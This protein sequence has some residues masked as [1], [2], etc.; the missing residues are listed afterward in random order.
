M[1]EARATKAKKFDEN[2]FVTPKPVTSARKTTTTSTSRGYLQQKYTNISDEPKENSSSIMDEIIQ[3]LPSSSSDV[4]QIRSPSVSAAPSGTKKIIVSLPHSQIKLPVST[5]SSFKIVSAGA[6]KDYTDFS[7]EPPQFVK[8]AASNL[9]PSVIEQKD[10]EVDES[11]DRSASLPEEMMGIEDQL[12]IQNLLSE[13]D[14]Q[15]AI[16]SIY[17]E[18]NMPQYIEEVITSEIVVDNN[19]NKTDADK[20]VEV[21]DESGPKEPIIY[22]EP[23]I[24]NSDDD[25]WIEEQ[26]SE[27][28]NQADVDGGE[29]VLQ[30]YSE[31]NY[32][33]FL[34]SGNYKCIN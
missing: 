2:L 33:E 17:D 16:N 4:H 25:D 13:K 1:K 31:E 12:L 23:S 29:Y 20:A 14:L 5:P 8:D 18:Q 6:L 28:I 30:S 24:G 15:T 19:E 10:I 9:E 21:I 27:L 32:L 26:Q 34:D 22:D 3:S 7:A 11:L